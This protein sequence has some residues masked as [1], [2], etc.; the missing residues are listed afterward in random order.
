MTTHNARLAVVTSTPMARHANADGVLVYEGLDPRWHRAR[1]GLSFGTNIN[2]T[3][4]CADGME[5]GNARSQVASGARKMNPKPFCTFFLD[6]DVVPAPDAWTKM[7]YYLKTRPE[8]DV[9]CGIYCA[10]GAAPFDPLIYQGNGMGAFWDFAVG[11][12]LT[13]KTHGI[14]AC[15]MGL[16]LIRTSLFDRLIAAGLV[17]GD[18]DDQEDCPFFKTVRYDKDKSR[19]SG[20]EDIYFCALGEKLDPPMQIL[21]DTS[22]LA[23]HI[24]RRTGISYGLAGNTSPIERAKWLPL[25]DGSGLRKDRKE[26]DEWTTECECDL[27]NGTKV[28]RGYRDDETESTCPKCNGVG[29]TKVPTPMRLAIDLGSGETRREWP[30]YITYTLDTRPGAETD[31]VQDLCALNLPLDHY[32]LVAS[33]HAF[34]HIGRWDQ[35]RLWKQVFA[36]TKPGGKIEIIVPN[37]EWAAARIVEGEVDFHALNVLYGSQELEAEMGRE[38]NH[39]KFGY[40]PAIIRA[41]AEQ[42]GFAEIEIKDYHS[43]PDLA[44][45]LILTAVKPEAKEVPVHET[46][47]VCESNRIRADLLEPEVIKT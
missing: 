16:T 30:G 1:M 40:T 33:R 34:E 37:L 19:F 22:V 42:A 36:I 5:I 31:Y 35:E 24:D 23:G 21:V 3:E 12:I 44:Y 20:T 41:L 47:G 43:D 18:G 10:K 39:H 29:T 2:T 46:N 6:R 17:H 28:W 45:H 14:T 7:F 32:D 15:H 4:I 25:P 26:A 11:D 9:V 8:I 38:F 13:T 27:C